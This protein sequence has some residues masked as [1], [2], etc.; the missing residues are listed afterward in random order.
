MDLSLSL[1]SLN[2]KQNPKD[3]ENRPHD[4]VCCHAVMAIVCSFERLS[5]L[6]KIFP[7]VIAADP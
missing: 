2:H 4:S 6:P 5:I 3:K 1:F 7:W